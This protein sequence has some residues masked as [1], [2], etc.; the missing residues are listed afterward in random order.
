[1]VPWKRTDS[2]AP[3]DIGR[4]GSRGLWHWLH[5]AT[6]AEASASVGRAIARSSDRLASRAV[7]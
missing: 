7:R 1:M 5:R 3:G 6:I 2:A 4:S